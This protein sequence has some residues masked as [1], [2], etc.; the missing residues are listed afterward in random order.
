M[1]RLLTLTVR[2]RVWKNVYSVIT[3]YDAFSSSHIT[4]EARVTRRIDL[5]RT[6]VIAGFEAGFHL[7]IRALEVHTL[8]CRYGRGSRS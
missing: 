8:P 2:V 7:R 6:D 3:N 5:S 4:R 1:T